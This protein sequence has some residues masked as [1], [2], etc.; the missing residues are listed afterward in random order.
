MTTTG[1][2]GKTMR[3][4]RKGRLPGAVAMSLAAFAAPLHAQQDLSEQDVAAFFEEAER[5]LTQAVREGNYDR[6]VD[7]T[8]ETIADGATFSFSQELYIGDERKSFT[9]ASLDK[10]DVLRLSRMAVGVMSGMQGLTVRDYTLDV[11]VVKVRPIGPGAAMATTRI[12][13]RGT[14]AMDPASGQAG[15]GPG[16]D[17][18]SGPQSLQVEATAGCSHVVQRGGSG[19]GL[20]IGMTVCES[21]ARI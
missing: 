18:G 8:Q 2:D 9:V 19:G 16:D 10:Q 17:S 5:D 13:E 15:A 21:R 3:I 1:D 4:R 7:W 11:E 14:L 12:T 20:M 6:L